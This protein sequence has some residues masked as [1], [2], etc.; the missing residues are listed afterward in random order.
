VE[1]LALDRPALQHGAL[2]GRELIQP[3]RQQR[4]DGR[5]DRQVA[6]AR[7]GSSASIS[8]TNSGLPPAVSCTR[9]RSRAPMPV[10]GGTI[11]SMSVA[12]SAGWSGS[13]S[14]VLALSLPPPQPGRESSSS[15]RAMHKIKMGA[16]G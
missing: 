10:P 15:G 9:S 12:V 3:R 1:R 11:S 13:S 2:G 14:S 8:S 5:R 4:G 16:S 6:A 7:L